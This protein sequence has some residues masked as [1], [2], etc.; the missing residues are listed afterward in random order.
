MAF[1]V[2]QCPGCESTFNT[3]ARILQSAAGK[4]RCGAC[5]TVFDAADNFISDHETDDADNSSVFVGN[6]PNDYF[7]PS[8]FF[9]R[10]ALT[11]PD[12]DADADAED[13]R[14]WESDDPLITTDEFTP[15]D[16]DSDPVAIFADPADTTDLN[17][18]GSQDTL[19]SVA[20]D[21]QIADADN[22]EPGNALLNPND[23]STLILPDEDV[24]D[25]GLDTNEADNSAPDIAP[26]SASWNDFDGSVDAPEIPEHAQE[27]IQNAQDNRIAP[28]TAPEPAMATDDDI[29]TVPVAPEL[30]SYS[31][32][33]EPLPQRWSRPAP[34]D[35]RLHASFSLVPAPAPAPE[36]E[37]EPEPEAIGI[38]TAPDNEPAS[39]A[40]DAAMEM[41]LDATPEHPEFFD[42][43]EVAPDPAA[44]P[45]SDD[46]DE[47]A[48][49]HTTL[50][51]AESEF[52]RE[53]PE[54]QEPENAQPDI[55]TPPTDLDAADTETDESVVLFTPVPV[56]DS[57]DT[58]QIDTASEDSATFD[59]DEYDEFEE[60][61]LDSGIAAAAES[62]SEPDDADLESVTD[63]DDPTDSTPALTDS[64]AGSASDDIEPANDT[65][66]EDSTESIRAR[67]FRS[68]LWDD[69]ALEALPEESRSAI[70]QHLPPVE[71]LSGHERRWTQR[72]LLITACTVLSLTL[73]AQ[74]FWQQLP[75]YSR[76]AEYRPLYELAC[77]YLSCNLPP[78]TEIGA[79]RSDN[80]VVR[81]HP[82]EDNALTVS[83]NFRN[84]A[85][86]PQPFPVLILSFNSATNAI[87]ALREFAPTEYLSE[88]LQNI[89]L[90]PVMSPV[91]V[92]LEIIDPGADALNYTVAFRR[93]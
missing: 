79:I 93:P 43:T 75:V 23:D 89:S 33:P 26:Q 22:L 8:V 69:E 3:T 5:L 35:I 55:G 4:V 65:P 2:T 12:A 50:P 30:E 27:D 41:D 77:N 63:Q 90:M 80:L 59:L 19:A 44:F 61:A 53:P 67:A 32:V 85:A 92:E 71:L 7:D 1:H 34:E 68:D 88:G 24:P 28:D 48:V 87:I 70:G 62:T 42:I 51:D 39:D 74:Y 15:D 29:D 91:Q 83:L 57:G 13:D 45:L 17:V 47:T 84:T 46:A 21:E 56:I 10:S 49:S 66:E 82:T 81:S 16:A 73:V 36:P 52:D 38:T 37:P 86:F 9:S 76:V 54:I 72:L 40:P 14:E 60:P 31:H 78:Y 6:N 25:A 64:P 11:A 18:Y 20:A 58:E